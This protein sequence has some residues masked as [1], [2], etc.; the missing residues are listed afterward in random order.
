MKLH[1]DALAD[2]LYLTLTDAKI[3][4]T[5]EVCPG[6]ILDYDE[7]SDVVGIEVLGLRVRKPPIDVRSFEFKLQ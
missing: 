6:V 7:H 3:V 2:A 5:G 4:E 1:V